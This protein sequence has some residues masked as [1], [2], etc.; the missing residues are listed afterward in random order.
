MGYSPDFEGHEG[1]IGS[2]SPEGAVCDMR[3][4]PREESAMPRSLFFAGRSL[5]FESCELGGT[6][7]EEPFERREAG[8]TG[9]EE[10]FAPLE[11]EIAFHCLGFGRLEAGGT[12]RERE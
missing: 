11:A 9:H 5:L 2:H 1:E 8:G 7:H 10:L 6:G 3:G 4:T 12:R